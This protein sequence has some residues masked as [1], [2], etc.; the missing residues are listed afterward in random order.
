MI[1]VSLGDLMD[2]MTEASEERSHELQKSTSLVD[3][4]EKTDDASLNIMAN[5][6]MRVFLKQ[7]KHYLF[8]MIAMLIF[9]Y[10]FNG[11]ISGQ[12]FIDV[13]YMWA[14]TIT[15]IVSSQVSIVYFI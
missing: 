3:K 15:T 4:Q 14:A 9:V 10:I 11:R 13:T 12:S 1:G 8:I 6:T 2:E 5:Y 7:N